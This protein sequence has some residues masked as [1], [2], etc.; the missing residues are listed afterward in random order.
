M[1]KKVGVIVNGKR[2]EV[3]VGDLSGS[4]IT[5]T[6]DGTDYA[7]EIEGGTLRAEAAGAPSVKTEA[8]PRAPVVPTPPPSIPKPSAPAAGGARSIAAPMPGKILAVA[9]K[10]GDKVAFGQEVCT[11]EAM[12][13]E[14]SIKSTADGVVKEVLVSPGDTVL[15]G[16]VLVE[17]E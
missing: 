15:Y 11:L 10:V 16:K 6:V 13:M 7:V 9:V 8:P 3:E 14:Q 12:K 1:A 2:Y 4:P 5:V 17:L